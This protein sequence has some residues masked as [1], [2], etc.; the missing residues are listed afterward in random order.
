MIDAFDERVGFSRQFYIG[1]IL[2]A[3]ALILMRPAYQRLFTVVDREQRD[4]HLDQEQSVQHSAGTQ[5]LR[6]Q[7]QRETLRAL[8][9]TMPKFSSAARAIYEERRSQYLQEK[10]GNRAV[11]DTEALSPQLQSHFRTVSELDQAVLNLISRVEDEKIRRAAALIYDLDRHMAFLM[12]STW[13]SRDLY[14]GHT[15]PH[16]LVDRQHQLTRMI[17][18]ALRGESIDNEVV[19]DFVHKGAHR[20]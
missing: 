3:A 14:A 13:D 18:K 8:Q 4:R 20:D 1:A 16:L 19:E 10:Q 17:G 11:S 2:I 6:E 7:E 12:P 9:D 5:S 15:P